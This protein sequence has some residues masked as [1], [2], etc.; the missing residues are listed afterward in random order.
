MRSLS[1]GSPESF[2]VAQPIIGERHAGPLTG[3]KRRRRGGLAY[4]HMDN[5][6]AFGCARIRLPHHVHNDE[7]I[8][9]AAERE[10]TG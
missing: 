6:L 9:L 10:R 8:D 2:G 4:L 3:G 1:S 5:V 7:G